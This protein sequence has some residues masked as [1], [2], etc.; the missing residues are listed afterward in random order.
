MVV[1]DAKVVVVFVPW[2]MFHGLTL[3]VVVAV[4]VC[5]GKGVLVLFVWLACW[6]W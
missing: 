6:G 3:R 5:F 1:V 2:L 4:C